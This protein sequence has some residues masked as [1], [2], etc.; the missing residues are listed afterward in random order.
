[1]SLDESS[2][3]HESV[4]TTCLKRV[5]PTLRRCLCE[6]VGLLSL[7]QINSIAAL[8]V[9]ETRNG[10]KNLEHLYVIGELQ[11]KLEELFSS[12]LAASGIQV[13]VRI[14]NLVWEPSDYRRCSAYFSPLPQRE[15]LKVFVLTLVETICALW[16]FTG[17][18]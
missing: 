11:S 10:L 3:R 4:L 12:V 1:M 14:K 7:I 17:Y 9:C 16:I 15:F 8:F 13:T 18:M 6:D 2:E 5:L